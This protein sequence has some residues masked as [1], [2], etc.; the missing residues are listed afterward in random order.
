MFSMAKSWKDE[1]VNL[2]LIKNQTIAVIGYGIQGH[3]QANNLKDSGLNVIVGLQESGS[4][5]KKA[6]QAGHKVMSIP[7]ACEN[8]DII[9]ILIPDMVQAKVYKEFI[10][11]HLKAGKA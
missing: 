9:H 2:D 4:S 10:G 6:Q 1:D 11:P 7:Q 5:W 8:S 3:A